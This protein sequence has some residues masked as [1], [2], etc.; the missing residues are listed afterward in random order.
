M[1]SV[2]DQPKGQFGFEPRGMIGVKG[3]GRV[4]AWL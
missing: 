3:K 4:E 1:H 2:Y